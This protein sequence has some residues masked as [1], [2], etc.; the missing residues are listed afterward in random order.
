ME[1]NEHISDHL[2]NYLLKEEK[3][4]MVDP[5]LAD[6]LENSESNKQ[7]FET[8]KKIWNESGSYIHPSVFDM[9]QAWKKVNEVNRKKSLF[10]K[11]LIKVG[12]VLSG[13]A[14][15]ILVI[16]TLS[17]FGIFTNQP[18]SFVCIT[19]DY[20]NRSQIV[21]P[22]GSSIKLNA[23]SDASY[24]YNPKKR[25]REVKFQGEGYFDVAKSKVPFVVKLTN[26]LE[27]KVWGTSFN[28]QAYA[29]DDVIQAS[30]VEGC[31]ELNHGTDKLVMKPGEIA[32]LDKRTNEIKR[33]EGILS[34]SY[35]WLDNKL[36][37]S[38][39]S[40]ADVCKNLERWYD[41]EITLP[42]GL[43]EHIH[44]NG[45]IQEETVTDVLEALSHL[46]NISYHVK[47][48]NISINSK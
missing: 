20:G 19:A 35:G 47:G 34:H 14:A 41:V 33:V 7:D 45:V 39:M 3:E 48:K 21:L 12:Y 6:W 5:E 16:L 24:F 26:G 9:E 28:L 42:P 23:G 29:D 13:T 37:M 17:F 8:Y 27:V 36:Y 4:Q 15:S 44:Y 40:L 10:R 32:V 25:V 22:D 11:N 46:S 30:L 18:E 31:I 1:K 38:D 43:G 2:V